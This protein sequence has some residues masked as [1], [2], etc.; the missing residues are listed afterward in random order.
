VAELTCLQMIQFLAY[1]TESR[2]QSLSRPMSNDNAIG[3]SRRL[4]CASDLLESGY[5]QQGLFYY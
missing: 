2:L 1:R 5:L 3:D 4:A